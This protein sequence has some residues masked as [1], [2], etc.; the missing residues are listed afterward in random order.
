MTDELWR[1][2]YVSQA[3]HDLSD[4]ELIDLLDVAKRLNQ[5][6]CITGALAYHDQRF[7]QILEGSRIAVHD[8]FSR[9]CRDLRNS[10]Q[11]VILSEPI[12]ERAFPDWSMGWIPAKEVKRAG[13]GLEILFSGKP[14]LGV[15]DEIFIAFRKIR[16]A[17]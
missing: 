7:L 12:V 5:R 6:D 13:F 14:A 1:L 11:I 8:V 9:I 3:S 16:Q 15:L 17:R 2:A 10:D 4:P